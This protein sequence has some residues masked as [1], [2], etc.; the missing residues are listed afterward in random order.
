MKSP[1][2]WLFVLEQVGYRK[3]LIIIFYFLHYL[4]RKPNIIKVAPFVIM[5]LY[6]GSGGILPSNHRAVSWYYNVVTGYNSFSSMRKRAYYP[7]AVMSALILTRAPWQTSGWKLIP[8][9]TFS[10][11]INTG[12]RQCPPILYPV[13]CLEGMICSSF[14]VRGPLSDS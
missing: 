4:S 1:I 14:L 13:G 8:A 11:T 2:V 12:Q 3:S 5:T 10:L 6:S 7:N 9:I